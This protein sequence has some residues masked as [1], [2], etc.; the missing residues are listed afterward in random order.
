M[1]A[2]IILLTQKKHVEYELYN[3]KLHDIITCV[4]KLRLISLTKHANGH[5]IARLM[6]RYEICFIITFV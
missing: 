3:Y 1:K 6:K 4:P 2:K 5:F